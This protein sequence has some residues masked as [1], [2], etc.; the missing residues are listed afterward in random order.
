[1]HGVHTLDA[2]AAH[3]M[4]QH[5]GLRFWYMTSSGSTKMKKL[6]AFGKKPSNDDSS[7]SRPAREI[8]LHS[9]PI[10]RLAVEQ[11]GRGASAALLQRFASAALQEAGQE[12]VTESPFA[13][14]SI[15]LPNLDFMICHPRTRP[16][17]SA[18]PP[19]K[20]VSRDVLREAA[21]NIPW[22]TAQARD[23]R[24]S[25]GQVESL[26]LRQRTHCTKL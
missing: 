17:P 26:C 14:L 9:S 18:H 15:F 5:I 2:I 23:G 24:R 22:L 16:H 19:P 25:L 6:L 20:P 4:P 13:E 8:S 7:T 3:G 10:T 12:A 21:Y 11:I 1:M